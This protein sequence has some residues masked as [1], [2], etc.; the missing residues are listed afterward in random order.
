M[1]SKLLRAF[2]LFCSLL[3]AGALASDWH[4]ILENHWEFRAMIRKTQQDCWLA[5]G[6][7]HCVQD[8][9]VRL[10]RKD[11]GVVW[12]LNSKDKTY[13]EE[14]I[15]PPK[16]EPA[17]REVDFHTLGFDYEPSYDWQLKETGEPKQ[18]LGFPCRG[19]QADGDADFAEM[20][21][22]FW[23][24]TE[25][26]LAISGAEND[27]VLGEAGP[28][29]AILKEALSKHPGSFILLIDSVLE[30]PIGD[31]NHRIIS[32][33]KLENAEAPAGIYEVPEGF[34]KSSPGKDQA[35]R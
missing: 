20:T 23:V 12:R 1:Q 18:I 19:F 10:V 8:G 5:D 33:L 22:K 26:A 13:I 3:P 9:R 15:E 14:K 30:P 21:V 27:L 16:A 34:K 31:T 32:V 28:A 4:V 2:W 6:R 29:N 7:S 11:L 35:A 24:C 25:P 17:K